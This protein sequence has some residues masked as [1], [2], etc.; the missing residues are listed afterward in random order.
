MIRAK[1]RVPAGTFPQV[2]G[3]DSSWPSQVYRRG[4]LPFAGNASEVRTKEYPLIFT[5]G[6]DGAEQPG[7]RSDTTKIAM[8]AALPINRPVPM[9]LN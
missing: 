4:I 1:L 2:R 3:G 6:G 5:G 7:R 8:I 9:N